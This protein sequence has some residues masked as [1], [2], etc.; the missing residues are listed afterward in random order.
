LTPTLCQSAYKIIDVHISWLC[1][2]HKSVDA[3]QEW[4]QAHQGGRF[5]FQGIQGRST[6][7]P[8]RTMAS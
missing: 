8:K 2:L 4:H 6:M 5:Y 3:I 1:K 7:R